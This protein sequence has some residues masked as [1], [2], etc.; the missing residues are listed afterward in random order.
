[1]YFVVKVVIICVFLFSNYVT[2]SFKYACS[3]LIVAYLNYVVYKMKNSDRLDIWFNKTF[4]TV[5]ISHK[6]LV[7]LEP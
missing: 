1:M 3:C 2:M 7:S 4:T 6:L 5:E